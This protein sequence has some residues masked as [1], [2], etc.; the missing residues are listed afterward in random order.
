MQGKQQLLQ[1]FNKTL[2][3]Q[4]I[5]VKLNY[6]SHSISKDINILYTYYY[7]NRNCTVHKNNFKIIRKH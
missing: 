7:F 2:L 6:H 4:N 3:T 5:Y 1:N